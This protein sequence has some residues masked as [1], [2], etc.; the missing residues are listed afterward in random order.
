[1]KGA[2]PGSPHRLALDPEGPGTRG[3]EEVSARRRLLLL[4]HA[5]EVA[6]GEPDEVPS[7]PESKARYDAPVHARGGERD[8]Q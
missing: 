3:V 6:F 5:H 2:H 7:S 1:V 4:L 8:R